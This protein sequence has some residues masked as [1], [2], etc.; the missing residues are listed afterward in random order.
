MTTILY[1][2]PIWSARVLYNKRATGDSYIN[3]PS[4]HYMLL[5]CEKLN[6]DITIGYKIVLK[7]IIRRII[8]RGWYINW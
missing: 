3:G 1:L 5:G 4:H 8:S 7:W 2:L 6:L